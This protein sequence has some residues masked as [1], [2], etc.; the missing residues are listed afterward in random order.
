M[1]QQFHFRC[2]WS[3]RYTSPSFLSFENFHQP[4][5]ARANALRLLLGI[6]NHYLGTLIYF[7]VFK[8]VLPQNLLLFSIPFTKF[9]SFA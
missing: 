3:P 7:M 4:P 8:F 9:H 2:C 6:A 1:T 5:P